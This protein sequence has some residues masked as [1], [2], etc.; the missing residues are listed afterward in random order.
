MGY[1]LYNLEDN[2]EFRWNIY[3][4]QPLLRLATDYGWTPEGTDI[5]PWYTGAERKEIIARMPD[6]KKNYT[7]NDGQVITASDAAKI[8][9]ALKIS[10]DD[11]PDFEVDEN[12]TNT[13]IVVSDDCSEDEMLSQMAEDFITKQKAVNIAQGA[14][15]DTSEAKAVVDNNPQVLLGRLKIMSK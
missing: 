9:N 6:Y 11:I 10:L 12:I 13:N 3:D 7:G 5:P 4:W 8:A 14:G 2:S 1:D 15:L